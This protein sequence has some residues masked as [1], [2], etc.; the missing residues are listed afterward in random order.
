MRLA[1]FEP[2]IPQNTGAILR[3]GACLGVP[4]D[5]IEPPGFVWSDRRLRRAGMDYLAGV[6]LAR[7][8]SWEAF[9]QARKSH[10]LVLL[11]TQGTTSY[12][13]FAF[14]A[15]D[16]LLFG[17]ESAG[18]PA[19]VHDAAGARII[20]PL[21]P[22]MRALNVALAAALVLGEALRQTGRLSKAAAP[23]LAG[24]S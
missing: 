2:D 22:G 11:T 15:D 14:R 3:L 13:D 6:D 10:R 12:A 18:V 4:V 21:M 24:V 17:R 7:H 16:I 20:I 1:L 23:D 8:V 9:L 19:E 5:I